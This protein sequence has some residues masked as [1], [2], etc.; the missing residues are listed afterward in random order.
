MNCYRMKPKIFLFC[1]FSIFTLLWPFSGQAQSEEHRALASEITR[2][3]ALNYQLGNAAEDI[4]RQFA[5]NPFQLEPAQSQN[6]LAAFK[7][8]YG[9]SLLLNDF[10]TL[11]SQKMTPDYA[12]KLQR[13]L[14]TKTASH[15]TELRQAF[16]TLQG[17]RQ[18][19]VAMYEME[20]QPPSRDRVALITTLLDTTSRVENT[21]DASATALRVF[22]E[23]VDSLNTQRSFTAAQ[24]Q[25]IVANFRSQVKNPL[26]EELKNRLLVL[27][28]P[29]KDEALEQYIAF[30]GTPMGQWLNKQIADGIREA[31]NV[32]A[33]R[34]IE[35]IST[36]T[37]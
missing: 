17:K 19:V 2:H 11:L 14:D 32:A 35:N 31:Y 23:A 15:I 18:R 22:I 5:Q 33:K 7:H 29:T 34:F 1:I 13:W 9:D 25:N 8:A 3:L 21:I 12:S 6:I 16:H 27:F 26:K 36:E 24:L 10:I 37:K 28:R 4:S 30:W 20:Q